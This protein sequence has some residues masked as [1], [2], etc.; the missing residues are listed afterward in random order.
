VDDRVGAASAGRVLMKVGHQCVLLFKKRR[1]RGQAATEVVKCF[2]D[3]PLAGLMSGV[4][5][6]LADARFYLLAFF[7]GG[8]VDELR[9]ACLDACARVARGQEASGE[10]YAACVSQLTFSIVMGE[11][12]ETTVVDMA[13]LAGSPAAV[14]AH[15]LRRV[16]VL[17]HALDVEHAGVVHNHWRWLR[18][19]LLQSLDHAR[20]SETRSVAD[21]LRVLVDNLTTT[22]T[23]AASSSSRQQTTS[24]RL[25]EVTRTQSL[26]ASI[27]ALLSAVVQSVTVDITAL[28]S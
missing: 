6:E 13:R 15:C 14:W 17:Q 8:D 7:P 2:S 22:T 23:T 5:F 28:V 26:L 3:E 21:R 18:F 24:L 4:F 9:S 10:F 12:D 19:D 16:E 11:D 1:R 20:C 27:C 25:D